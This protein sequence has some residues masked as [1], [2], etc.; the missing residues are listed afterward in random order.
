DV[1]FEP[2]KTE[3]AER[4]TEHELQALAHV[5]APS[6]RGERVVAEVGATERPVEDLADVVDPG[7]GAVLPATHEQALP[8]GRPRAPEPS[9]ARVR[10]GRSR[11]PVAVPLPTG[12]RGLEELVAVA[13][14]RV[15]QEDVRPAGDRSS[16]ASGHWEPS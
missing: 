6:E 15:A 10:V 11:H 4:M 16:R 8:V 12:V 7:D 1:G 2:V 9:R 13:R 5:A 14:R 3:W